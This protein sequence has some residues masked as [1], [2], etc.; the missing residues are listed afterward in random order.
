[1]KNQAD[2]TILLSKVV[3]GTEY[4]SVEINNNDRIV[5]FT[6]KPVAVKSSLVNAGVYLIKKGLLKSLRKNHNYSLEEVLLPTWINSHNIFGYITEAIFQDIGTPE[7][8]HSF[9]KDV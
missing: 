9:C 6:E 7:R 3:G 5:N 1:M 2:M 4:G 8:Y